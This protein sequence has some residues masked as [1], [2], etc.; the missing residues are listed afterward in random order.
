[1]TC[2]ETTSAP[3]MTQAQELSKDIPF[4]AIGRKIE[5]DQ[6]GTAAKLGDFSIELDYTWS[7]DT[8]YSEDLIS[9]GQSRL[10]S[11]QGLVETAMTSV[12][13]VCRLVYTHT[14]FCRWRGESR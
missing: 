14:K 5:H 2:D 6:G 8:Q 3:V 12:L 7:V 13:S 9:K 1:M 4:G 11:A 10:S